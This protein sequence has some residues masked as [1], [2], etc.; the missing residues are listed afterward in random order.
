M[1]KNE[2]LCH[3]E[4]RPEQIPRRMPLFFEIKLHTLLLLLVL[5]MLLV[6]SF[7]M[8][9]K[10]LNI[11]TIICFVVIIHYTFMLLR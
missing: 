7:V 3:M 5:L 4:Q 6:G 1:K 8:R 11:D 9:D 10:H 2:R